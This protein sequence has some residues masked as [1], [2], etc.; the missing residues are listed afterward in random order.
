MVNE[1]S[2][3]ST[4]V[5]TWGNPRPPTTPTAYYD[6]ISSSVMR[7]WDGYNIEVISPD[8]SYCGRDP[9]TL[10]GGIF[11]F[12]QDRSVFQ[13]ET[14]KTATVC[15]C[16]PL[17]PFA[18]VQ[19]D[20]MTVQTY[21]ADVGHSKDSNTWQPL[22]FFSPQN[23]SGRLTGRSQ[24]IF[25]SNLTD[26]HLGGDPKTYIAGQ[27]P[28][29]IPSLVPK[30]YQNQLSPTPS[31]GLGGDLSILLGLMTFTAA[32][33]HERTRAEGV[34]CGPNGRWRNRQWH[35]NHSPAGC[36]SSRLVIN[37]TCEV[38]TNCC[39]DNRLSSETPQVLIIT[40]ALDPWNPEGSTFEALEDFEFYA[41][42]V[43]E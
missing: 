35:Y 2:I 43:K 11:C 6:E 41:V 25:R 27:H 36:T 37:P 1:V 29:W 12:N 23:D 3:A 19:A 40:I 32:R 31:R 4:E 39:I 30:T 14:Y 34:F 33:V 28:S 15:S 24:A 21:M 26:E 16:H 8:I 38:C 13:A 17:M 7:F 18:M 42:A 20:V 10:Q 9:Q 22:L 5:D